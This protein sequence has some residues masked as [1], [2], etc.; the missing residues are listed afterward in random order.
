MNKGIKLRQKIHNILY[1]IH[2]NNNTIDNSYIK[3]KVYNL[4]TRDKAFINNVCLN[5]MRY[6]FHTK[7]IISMYVKKKANLNERFILHSGITQILYL[8]FKD[9]A[10]V[11]SSVELAK[12]MN[13]FHGFINAVLKKIISNKESLKKISITYEDLPNWFREKTK[14]FSK[15]EKYN[16]TK[17][18][19]EKP[20]LHLVFKSKKELLSFEEKIIP[21][22]DK[23]GFLAKADKVEEIKSYK[24]GDWWV[25]DFSSFL[26]LN[27]L[28]MEL[29]NKSCIDLC[30]APGGKSFQI[31]SKTNNVV[32]NDKNKSRISLL[33]ENLNRLKYKAKVIN[34][35]AR[36]LNENTKYD[37]V[38]LDAPCSA[39]GTIRKNP[40]IFFRRKNP[41]FNYLNNIQWDMLN[42]AKNIVKNKGLILY[43]VCSFLKIE[44]IDIISNFIEINKNFTLTR[45]NM[46]KDN[47]DYNN[48][49]ENDLMMTLPSKINGYNI[50]GY[51]AAYLKKSNEVY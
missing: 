39:M 31:L 20:N 11:N 33:N 43:M 40:E 26:P 51:F 37:L 50:D 22:S 12:K 25:Q 16:F 9:Y 21:T 30:S 14:N 19:Y 6:F 47:F 36:N 29:K 7:K 24:K 15:L 49:V 46:N 3:F 27:L 45:F 42:K 48:F 41:D 8:D 5:T 38:I 17:C 13:I 18:F 2:V 35:D 4:E 23:S 44:T 32:L 28:D 34:N 1:D 10:V